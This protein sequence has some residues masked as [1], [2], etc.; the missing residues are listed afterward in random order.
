MNLQEAY[1]QKAETPDF[2][3][4]LTETIRKANKIKGYF[5]CCCC[6]A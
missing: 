3:Y 6:S 2:T 5:S 1:K 4:N